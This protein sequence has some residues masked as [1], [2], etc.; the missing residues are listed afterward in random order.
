MSARTIPSSTAIA[1]EVDRLTL[2]TRQKKLPAT[3]LA[4]FSVK[5]R[6]QLDLN[7]DRL[8]DGKPSID[9]TCTKLLTEA[10]LKAVEAAYDALLLFSRLAYLVD[11]NP[12]LRPMMLQL[13]AAGVWQWMLFLFN[14]GEDLNETIGNEGRPLSRLTRQVITV[15]LVDVLLG[16]ADSV[17]LAKQ[18]VIPDILSLIGRLWFE[19]LEI[20]GRRNF[21]HSELTFTM[22]HL[23]NDNAS[24]DSV[25]ST[26]IKAIGGGAKNIMQAA[27]DH[28]RRLVSSVPPVA[29]S[30]HSQLYFIEFLVKNP[31]FRDAMHEVDTLSVAILG[32]DAFTKKAKDAEAVAACI[33]CILTPHLL[34][35]MSVKPLVQAINKGLLLS[36]YDARIAFQS[37]DY[38]CDVIAEVVVNVIAPALAFRSVL[39]AI[40][41]SE[42]KAGFLASY[43]EIRKSNELHEW[44]TLREFYLETLKFKHELDEILHPCGR[45]ECPTNDVDEPIKLQRCGKCEYQRYCSRECQQLDWPKHKRRCIKEAGPEIYPVS[46][47][48]FVRELAEFEIRKN[49]KSLKERIQKNPLLKNSTENLHFQVDFSTLDRNIS[50]GVLPR[51]KGEERVAA[52]YAKVKSGREELRS[53]GRVAEVDELLSPRSRSHVWVKE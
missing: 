27:T 33:E 45:T 37:D 10:D 32:V 38:C 25:L 20:P 22:Y 31:T 21:V 2:A 41:R 29:K 11:Q 47:R 35:G 39:H 9:K 12:E 34:S 8:P 16:C 46:D 6:L 1:G 18:L 4:S 5:K 14:C 49:V 13:W 43:D 26:L 3:F 48:E 17:P 23:L 44:E 40:E 36:L 7:A 53:L 28:F 24:N 51:R 19:D 50:I 42:T 15:G 52:V 30:V